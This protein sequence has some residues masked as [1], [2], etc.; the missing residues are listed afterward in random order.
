[1]PSERLLLHCCQQSIRQIADSKLPIETAL[2]QQVEVHQSGIR[3]RLH[4]LS[5]D[6]AEATRWHERLAGSE[7]PANLRLK[8]ILDRNRIVELR[9]TLCV[10]AQSRLR[11]AEGP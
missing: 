8:V 5:L 2:E 10:Y 3:I 1:M 7:L 9:V 6:D 4:R 11:Q